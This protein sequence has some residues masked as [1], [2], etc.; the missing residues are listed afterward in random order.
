MSKNDRRQNNLF[1]VRLDAIR[2]LLV[3][4]SG[5]LKCI[6]SCSKCAAYSPE[7]IGVGMHSLVTM[8]NAI[9]FHGK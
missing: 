8:R 5:Q 3:S 6:G 9:G 4:A 7:N 2:G 1:A